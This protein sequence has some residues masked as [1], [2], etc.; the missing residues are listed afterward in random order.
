MP[1][2]PAIA[3]GLVHTALA[4]PAELA[5][6]FAAMVD[7]DGSIARSTDGDCTLS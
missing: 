3:A 6:R 2:G 4:A 5:L 1:T 7:A